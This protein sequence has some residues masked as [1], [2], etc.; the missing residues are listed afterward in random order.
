MAATPCHLIFIRLCIHWDSPAS[1]A[2]AAAVAAS[3][4]A[5]IL[6]YGCNRCWQL[7]ESVYVYLSS[8][9]SQSNTLCWVE[10]WHGQCCSALP[11]PGGTFGSSVFSLSFPFLTGSIIWPPTPTPPPTPFGMIQ[12]AHDK[13]RSRGSWMV[14]LVILAKTKGLFNFPYVFPFSHC[15]DGLFQWSLICKAFNYF[16]GLFEPKKK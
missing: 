14:V 12:R 5:V 2:A 4:A 7:Y 1:S 6:L 13:L 10:G 9:G 15:L 3:V 16:L 8:Q 11:C